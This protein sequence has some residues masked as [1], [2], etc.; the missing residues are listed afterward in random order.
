MLLE[1]QD[2]TKKF[3]GITALDS[4]SLQIDAGELVALIGP[5]GAGKTTFFNCLLGVLRP[6]DGQVTFDGHDLTRLPVHERA[7][8]GIARTFQRIELFG[9]MTVR[10][11]L[12]VAA[13]ARTRRGELF[14]DLTG[15][16]RPTTGERAE[17]ERVL[18]LVGLADLADRQAESLSLGKGR[19]VEL[20]RAL[21]CRPRLLF[22][23][24]PSSGLDHSET[25]EM[26]EVLLS[27]QREEGTAILL[28]EHDVPMVERLAT[29]TAVLDVGVL[30][31]SGPT[32]EVLAS[33]A[34]RAAYLG[35]GV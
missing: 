28:V 1:A 7:R 16:S 21:M 35:S 10:E 23:D 22:L 18:E 11:H 3:A 6:D 14:G 9:G 25:L 5:N 4:V 30:I 19:L 24:E 32:A 29:R 12:L 17:A 26:G 27:V 34:V 33:P 20:A 8:L 15:R 13:R 2:V 31:A